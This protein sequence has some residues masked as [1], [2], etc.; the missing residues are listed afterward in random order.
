M[1]QKGASLK[2][3]VLN[4]AG[5]VWLMV[6][7]GGA[8]VIYADTVGDLGFAAELGNVRGRGRLG[9]KRGQQ[10]GEGEGGRPFLLTCTA[11]THTHHT[12]VTTTTIHRHLDIQKPCWQYGEYSGAPNTNETYQYARTVLGAATGEAV[13][14][15]RGRV[16]WTSG[17]EEAA[18]G[19]LS[20]PLWGPLRCLLAAS[21]STRTPRANNTPPPCSPACHCTPPPPPPPTLHPPLH[22]A[23]N[24]DGRGRALLIGGGIANFTDVAA[25]FRGIIQAVREQVR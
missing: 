2:F 19:V 8:S 21:T 12:F 4:P 7:G 15:G 17:G 18:E 16:V 14:R 23:A 3:T 13:E 24:P 5:R 6:A 22:L 25:T 20:A 10:W 11:H 9:F 1:N